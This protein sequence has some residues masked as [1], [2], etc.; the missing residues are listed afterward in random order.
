MF[1]DYSNFSQI[2]QNDS[3]VFVYYAQNHVVK[4]LQ[5]SALKTFTLP[6][7]RVP[8]IH[9]RKSSLFQEANLHI[10][11]AHLHVPI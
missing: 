1:F 7:Q 11:A 9:P 8:Q 3:L 4:Y 5:I 6:Q 10:Y 2:S